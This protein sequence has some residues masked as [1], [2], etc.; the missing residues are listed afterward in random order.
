MIAQYLQ[1]L[2]NFATWKG[3]M[4]SLDSQ[5][6]LGPIQDFLTIILDLKLLFIWGFCL[7]GTFLA[8]YHLSDP[9]SNKSYQSN[10]KSTANTSKTY[11]EKLSLRHNYFKLCH[12]WN[13]KWIYCSSTWQKSQ[14]T[15]THA[16]QNPSQN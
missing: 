1:I 12:N 7:E 6:K 11:L 5:N 14:W 3:K 16:D 15:L 13:Y 2:Q 9:V 10:I 4:I 8:M